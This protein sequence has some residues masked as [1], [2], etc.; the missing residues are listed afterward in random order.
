VNR[1]DRHMQWPPTS[2]SH[3]SVSQ[4]EQLVL[5]GIKLHAWC[6]DLCIY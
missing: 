1:D 4:R 3:G 2:Q 6:R 5:L